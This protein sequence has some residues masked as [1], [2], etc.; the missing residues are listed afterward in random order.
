MEERYG[1]LGLYHTY[2]G[3]DQTKPANDSQCVNK[4]DGSDSWVCYAD[5]DNMLKPYT[6]FAAILA[7]GGKEE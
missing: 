1:Y 4:A 3:C 7:A 5:W 6:A 2:L